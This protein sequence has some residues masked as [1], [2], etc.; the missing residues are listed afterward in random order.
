MNSR[1]A[2]PLEGTHRL[3]HLSSRLHKGNTPAITVAF[4][5]PM[6]HEPT[7][8]QILEALLDFRDAVV[9]KLEQHDRRFDAHDQRFDNLERRMGRLE[10]RMEDMERH[11]SRMETRMDGFDRRLPA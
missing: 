2:L 6:A 7:T 3:F 5:S 10:T 1:S 9:T 8:G 11:M 4:T